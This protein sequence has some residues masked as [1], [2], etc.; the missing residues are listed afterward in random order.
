HA[1]LHLPLQPVAP[2]ADLGARRVAAPPA[3]APAAHSAGWPPL[4]L[5]LGGR[6]RS[7]GHLPGSTLPTRSPRF[8]ARLPRRPLRGLQV[9][10]EVDAERLAGPGETLALQGLLVGGARRQELDDQGPRGLR[11]GRLPQPVEQDSLRLG[12][13][14]L[15]VEQLP[16]DGDDLRRLF[17]RAVQYAPEHVPPDLRVPDRPPPAGFRDLVQAGI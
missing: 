13:L 3:P 6:V 4:L 17:P 5:G 8:G 9:R 1:V 7:I 12:P 16:P 2:D 14:R 11:T 15:A 10:P